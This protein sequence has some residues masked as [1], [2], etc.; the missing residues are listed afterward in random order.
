VAL[1]LPRKQL[2]LACILAGC[3]AF[4]PSFVSAL[5]PLPISIDTT[6]VN[7]TANP[8][9]RIEKS[10]KFWNGTDTY[11]PLHLEAADFAAQGEE[12]QI[13]VDGAEDAVNSLRTWVTPDIPDLDVAPKQDISLGF[14][15]DVPANADPGSHWGTLL[16]ITAPQSTGGPGIG[17]QA[18]LGFIIY[19]R[20]LG[21]AREKVTLESFSVPRFVEEPP[22]ALE[23]RFRN[24]GTVHEA[25][26]G[27]I[28]VRNVFGTLVA[29]GTLPVRNVLPGVVRKVEGSVGPPAGGGF[30]FGRYTVN[31]AAT[32][33]DN[34]EKLSATRTI[35]V[36]P[37][38]KLWPWALF[39]AVV[40]VL[41]VI[42]RKRFAAA[43][44]V[45]RTGKEPPG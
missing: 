7:I 19:V 28:E 11:L 43:L 40:V 39:A 45:L 1:K 24:E 18:R 44:Y 6:Y 3:F 10:F 17:V 14:A 32:Y 33:G 30:W 41:G 31:F 16:S 26:A 22:V 25:P 23:E 9:E 42:A 13:V 38:H 36:V 37:W 27:N 12:G 5:E 2:G 8:G 15:I 20:V 4:L 29:T 35:W 34:G 21:D